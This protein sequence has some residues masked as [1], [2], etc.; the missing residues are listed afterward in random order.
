[1]ALEEHRAA[2][3]AADA[4]AAKEDALFSTW[5]GKFGG[6]YRAAE[7]VKAQVGVHGD[8][9]IFDVLRRSPQ[10]VA[11]DVAKDV[12]AT[13]SAVNGSWKVLDQQYEHTPNDPEIY[14]EYVFAATR[15]SSLQHLARAA[16]LH[17]L[18]LETVEAY[19][20]E[21]IR[22]ASAVSDSQYQKEN[23]AIAEALLDLYENETTRA[24]STRL[25]LKQ[26]MTWR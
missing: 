15:R 8:A 3:A 18:L 12:D 21:R 20:R 26:L 4:N 11:A 13:L 14:C 19:F 16:A 17:R 25:L 5:K 24:R 7:A 2:V 6:M 10:A 23:Q 1:L 22:V 9:S